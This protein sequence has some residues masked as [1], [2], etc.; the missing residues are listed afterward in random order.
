MEIVSDESGKNLRALQET[1]QSVAPDL[2][3]SGGLRMILPRQLGELESPEFIDS[4]RVKTRAIK[5]LQEKLEEG[6]LNR[7]DFRAKVKDI[8]NPRS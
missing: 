5:N 7:A 2:L 3:G 4:L 1:L 6:S 8:L